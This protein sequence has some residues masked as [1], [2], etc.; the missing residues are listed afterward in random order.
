MT[1]TSKTVG[2]ATTGV[3]A[4]V[5]PGTPSGLLDGDLV[6]IFA[7]IR[8]NGAGTVNTPSGWTRVA[9]MENLAVLGRYFQTGDTMP[10]V[11]FT[12][13]VANAD[14][15]ARAIKWRG[16]GLDVLT[17]SAASTASNASAANITTPS[18]NLP[19]P[20]HAVVMFVWKQDDATSLSTPSTFTADGLTNMTTG[21]DMLAAL[22][23][24][25]Q[26]TEAD[27][28]SGTITV[29]GGGSAIGRSIILGIKPA[30]AIAVTAF[31][32]F[33]PRTAVTVTGLTPGDDVV[34]YRVVS[35]ERAPLRGGSASAVTDPSFVVVDGEL[36]FGVPVSYVVVVNSV[37]EYATT[38]V[39]YDLP[40]GKPVLSDAVTGDSSQF[41][42]TRWPSKQYDPQAS[43]FKAGGRNVVVRGDIGQWEGTIELFFEAWSS[44][45]NFLTVIGNATQ[46]VLQLRRPSTEYNGVDA[47]VAVLSASEERFSQD[48]TDD[49][50]T[51]VLEVAETDP[52]ADGLPAAAYTLQDIADTY[53]G[54]T[55][56]DLA[57]DFGSLLEITSADFS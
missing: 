16:T 34:V 11:T 33:P 10:T 25:T 13:G 30:P 3:N 7:A 50:R 48:G 26:T 21:D 45:E 57:D 32:L 2:T 41:V 4:S 52:W 53:S 47:Y 39:T 6:L 35:G 12:G 19:G 46:G 29:T 55:L 20:D 15:Y 31:D 42:I 44:S 24:V 28:S 43:V 38:G 9:T 51:W 56:A 17:E 40:G 37:A 27:I 49:R 54:L 23:S 5:V 8:N 22:F 18:L 1:I 14:T 36:P